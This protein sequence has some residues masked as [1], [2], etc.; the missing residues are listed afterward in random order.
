MRSTG[1][2]IEPGAGRE[3]LGEVRLMRRVVI[4]I[5]VVLLIGCV[6]VVGIGAY[7][8][9]PLLN[10]L[11][12]A[13]RD[14][15]VQVMRDALYQ[16][17][18]EAIASGGDDAGSIRIRDRDLTVNNTAVAG[19]AGWETGTSGTVVYGFDVWFTP[20]GVSLG[21]QGEALYSGMPSVVGGRLELADVQAIEGPSFMSLMSGED[22]ETVIE[23]GLNDAFAAH[24]L[25]PTGLTLHDG[26]MIVR[27]LPAG[28]P[29]AATPREMGR[30]QAAG[31]DRIP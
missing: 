7:F 30:G 14:N 28:A 13:G 23:G 2:T 8:G 15:V 24:E 18:F 11:A 3:R 6:G 26:E 1:P 9:L 25:T 19:E 29:P 17:S 10:K 21:I 5:V 22:F 20:D 31:S 4:G 16:S 27:V 12:E